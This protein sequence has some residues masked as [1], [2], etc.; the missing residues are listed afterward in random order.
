[1]QQGIESM[2]LRQD[3]SHQLIVQTQAVLST[4][5]VQMTT[6]L[7]LLQARLDSL[8]KQQPPGKQT[9]QIPDLQVLG[10]A[11]VELDQKV[12]RER[13]K[14]TVERDAVLR[15]NTELFHSNQSLTSYSQ[16]QAQQLASKKAEVARL[17]RDLQA[18]EEQYN[19]LKANTDPLVRRAQAAQAEQRQLER[20]AQL[21]H[22]DPSRLS[23]LAQD[24][25]PIKRL[26]EAKRN[27]P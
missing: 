24:G 2:N 18:K 3:L 16:Q 12:K 23:A 5:L 22:S 13:Q 8:E 27:R 26:P 17:Q 9:V 25:Y 14:M 20:R 10:E 19:L 15:C 4:A 6:T 7:N 11:Y 1:M 21:L